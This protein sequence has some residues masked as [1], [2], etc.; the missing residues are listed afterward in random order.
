MNVL[1]K[2]PRKMLDRWVEA[3]LAQEAERGRLAR[4]YRREGLL[5]T[6]AET[7]LSGRGMVV[8]GERGVGKSALVYELVTRAVGRRG[9]PAENPA[10]A[11]APEFLAGRRV[12]QISIR[13]AA[14]TL[15]K[16]EA[17]GMHM[18][19]LVDVLAG[20]GDEVVV[21]LRDLH[22]TWG[23]DLE[24]H[25]VSLAYS[26][27]HPLIAEG[28]GGKVRSLFEYEP[29]LDHL[30]T[31]IE[32]REP[33]LVQARQMLDAW[34]RDRE[35]AAGVRVE[36]AACEEAL[37]L[38]HRFLARSRL[39]RKAILPLEQLVARA[40]PGTTVRS[41]D[42]G[43]LLCRQYGLPPLLVDPTVPL[44]LAALEARLGEAVR[45]QPEAVRAV[46]A[47]AGRIKAGLLDPHRP[48]GLFLFVGPSGVGK[49]HLARVLAEEIL[50]SRERLL[51]LNMAD[52]PNEADAGVLFGISSGDAEVRRGT[53][54]RLVR[55]CQFGVLLLDEL[56][57]AAPAIQDRFLQ[58]FDEGAFI[59]GAGETVSCRA[60][61]IVATANA[62]SGRWEE[63]APGFRSEG[64]D[65]LGALDDRLRRHFRFELLNRFD[66][67]VPF[68][69]LSPAE[70]RALVRRELALLER[71][72]GLERLGVRLEV[73]EEAL[74]RLM[75]EGYDPR[76]GAR[77]L[78]RTLERR[79]SSALA[80][81][82]VASSPVPG[83]TLRVRLRGV[84][85]EVEATAGPGPEPVPA[86]A[87][88]T[89]RRTSLATA[90]SWAS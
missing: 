18:L 8:V 2:G 66:E 5:R 54:A 57:K 29:Q 70:V 82:L 90:V 28:E 65:P 55:G 3:D 27:H 15:R 9:V 53:L 58:L 63:H 79:V 23:F 31:L 76:H 84:R 60:L 61:V 1:G 42:V 64:A 88:P 6:A 71:R 41:S 40:R 59:N 21:F 56:D 25:V 13:R 19:E 35:A 7:L 49:T 4:A 16:G 44:D 24:E 47:M 33:N 73:D 72:P 67:I 14:S 30:L 68:A 80:A 48:F 74:D 43:G 38:S 37:Q 34:R 46:V 52:Y 36:P 26:L 83:T 11:T 32:V 20:M 75:A 10:G 85:F 51:R 39:P 17:L 50:G 45:G 62:G 12:L 81:W 69:P 89:A 87:E 86:G 77:F 78:R 22:L